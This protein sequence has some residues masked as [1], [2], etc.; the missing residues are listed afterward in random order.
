MV[1]TWSKTRSVK[2]PGLRCRAEAAR[3]CAAPG[4]QQM[5]FDSVKLS[6]PSF[7][8]GAVDPKNGRASTWNPRP[9]RIPPAC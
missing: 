3:S 7:H 2:D 4:G 8:G 9:K 1:E 5:L 6:E